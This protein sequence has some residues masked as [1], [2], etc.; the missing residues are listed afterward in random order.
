MARSK[1]AFR[2]RA[3]PG[4]FVPLTQLQAG[5]YLIELNEWSTVLLYR[6][7]VRS[8]GELDFG[9][10]YQRQIKPKQGRKWLVLDVVSK[11]RTRRYPGPDDKG[12]TRV[13]SSFEGDGEPIEGWL[14]NRTIVP[15]YW[16][17]VRL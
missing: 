5:D 10:A 3:K 15:S 17:A 4:V 11:T 12:Y 7:K 9:V 1:S 13:L 6:F 16:K 8:Q 14:E 2:V